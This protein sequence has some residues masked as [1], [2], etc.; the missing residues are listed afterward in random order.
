MR[1]KSIT[2]EGFRA[3]GRQATFDLDADVI[4]LHGPNGVGKTSLL[5][6]ILWTLAGEIARFGDRGSPISLYA[7]EGQ[8]RCEL[9]LSH[10]GHDL[11]ITRSALGD[12]TGLR[13][14]TRQEVLDGASAEQTLAHILLPHLKDR[15]GA[16]EALGKILTRGVY[17]QQDLVR[18]F[19]EE[20]S[21]VDRFAF[22]SEVIGA[23]AVLEL[24]AA[25]ERSRRAWALSTNSFRK[26]EIEPA[27]ARLAQLQDHLSRLSD[28]V[29]VESADARGA[30][31]EIFN[32]SVALIGQTRLGLDE[33]P[34]T[35]ARLDRFLKALR[36]ERERLSREATMA[37][38]LFEQITE[39]AELTS[40]LDDEARTLA[41]MED[42]LLRQVEAAD[43]RVEEEMARLSRQRALAVAEADGADRAAT[44]ARLAL[45]NLGATCPVCRQ[46]HDV[47]A[48]IRHLHALIKAAS[49][50]PPAEPASDDLGKLNQTR[51]ELR[52]E[53]EQARAALRTMQDR[54]RDRDARR[55]LFEARLGDLGLATDGDLR[56]QLRERDE[57]ARASLTALDRLIADADQLSLAVL[58]LGEQQQRGALEAERAQLISKLRRAELR[59]E[60]EDQTHALAGRIIDGLRGASLSVTERQ[61]GQI[62]PLFQRIYNRIDPHPTFRLTQIVAI[63]ERGK[64]RLDV[65]VSDPDGDRKSHNASPLL[66]SSQLN[67]FAVSLFL[68]M[69]LALPTLKLGV[70]IL[71]DPLQSLDS[72]NLL[73]LVDVLRRFGAHRQIIL[74]THEERLLGLLQRKLRPVGEGERLVTITFES[75]SRDGPTYRLVGV[76]GGPAESQIIAA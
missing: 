40:P 2:I 27:R 24:Q 19:I 9:V 8:A 65:G 54:Q 51:S 29:I 15:T 3:F 36:S 18:Q 71:D 46:Q 14:A 42:S 28:G 72:I 38:G 52:R 11:T 66:S 30:A 64:G 7:R 60:S 22:V 61:I 62:A 56:D 26:D 41:E 39:I 12:E 58:R 25:L 6:A 67:S 70:T 1:L 76:D 48:T 32:R 45:Q 50:P 53:L 49:S 63:M 47:E 75:W 43:A 74:S 44:L 37:M 69:N 16:R 23:G 10:N 31:V 5:D 17:L 20:D 33:P 59:A 34:L 13:V 73:G 35:P 57:R 21:A 55:K 68:A 4:L